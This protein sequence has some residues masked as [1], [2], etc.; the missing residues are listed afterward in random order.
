MFSKYKS[1]I[2]F[3]LLAY[4]ITWAFHLGGL[5]LAEAAGIQISNE[6]NFLTLFNALRGQ[7]PPDTLRAVGVFSLGAGPLLAALIVTAA[8]KGR[9]GL[10][11]IWRSLTD[12]RVG[13]KWV[14]VALGL[15]LLFAAVSVLL[16]LLS[17]QISLADY[18]PA[19]PF[20]LLLPYFVFTF[21]FTG[22]WEEVGWRGF[23]LP[24][25][26]KH[27]TA[28]KASWILGPLWALWHAPVNYQH[29]P[30]GGFMFVYLLLVS[31]VA[32]VGFTTL[33]TW[34]YNNTKGSL[35]LAVLLHGW[36]NVVQTYAITS[37]GNPM[38]ISV[39]NVVPWALAIW[40]LKKYGSQNLAPNER[41]SIEG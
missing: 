8:T 3:F 19:L 41:P 11:A 27:F 31:M 39:F 1:L 29:A 4:A 33:F 10:A 37:F 15:P 25:L 32:I 38:V 20:S 12:V 26:Q 23:A 40:L 21:I 7:A 2:V 30:G 28:E 22:V 16:G 5:R 17:G 34:L 36:Y 35:F 24:R 9:A 13:W 6:T 14:L 18:A